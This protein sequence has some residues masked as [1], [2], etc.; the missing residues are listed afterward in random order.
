[1]PEEG[2]ENLGHNEILSFKEILMIVKAASQIG[3]RKIKITGGEPLVRKDITDLIMYIKEI[4]GIEEVTMTTNGVLLGDMAQKLVEAGLDSVNVS[5]DTM[6]SESFKNI[7][8][9]TV[10]MRFYMD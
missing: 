1:M 8:R 5:L 10:L 7:T 9:R 6:D 4:N 2:V 3:I